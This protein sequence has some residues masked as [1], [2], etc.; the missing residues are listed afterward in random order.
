MYYLEVGLGTWAKPLA[1]LFAV[2]GLVGC[3]SLFQVNQLSGLLYADYGVPKA[4]TGAAATLAVGIV[5]LGGIVRVGRVASRVVPAMA[6]L[7]FVAALVIVVQHAAQVPGLIGSIIT[8]AFT[9][10]AAVGGAA[11]ITMKEALITGVRRAAFSNE[12]GMGT[13]QV[14]QGAAR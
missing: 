2:C 4:A 8:S 9:G 3:L 5:I 12:A 14:A 1:M 13:V 6:I 7:Y 11:G 10:T